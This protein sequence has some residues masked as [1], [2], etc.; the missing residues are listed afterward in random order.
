MTEVGTV[1]TWD[2]A[3]GAGRIARGDLLDDLSFDRSV[4][5]GS[6]DAEVGQQVAYEMNYARMPG[7]DDYDWQVQSVRVVSDDE[8][9]VI[10][11]ETVCTNVK[12][13]ESSLSS[14]R[15]L[16]T[17]D[18][19]ESAEAAWSRAYNTMQSR[20]PEIGRSLYERGGESMMREILGR[21]RKELQIVITV[22]WKGIG[23]W[24]GTLP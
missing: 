10:E 22:E 3:T 1:T 6:I 5:E 11:L 19:V 15:D 13:A 4:L 8:A 2:T 9:A 23:S 16:A 21:V 7:A 20:V 14:A 18:D 24:S 12:S 17:E